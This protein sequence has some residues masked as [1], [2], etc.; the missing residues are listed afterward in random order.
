MPKG[1]GMKNKA[2]LFSED[3]KGVGLALCFVPASHRRPFGLKEVNSHW[4]E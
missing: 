2:S 1:S 3:K 4:K